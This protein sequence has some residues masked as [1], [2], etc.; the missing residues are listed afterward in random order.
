LAAG[1]PAPSFQAKFWARVE[2]DGFVPPFAIRQLR[3]VPYRDAPDA[4]TAWRQ[5]A[6]VAFLAAGVA[7]E[8]RRGSA[9]RPEYDVRRRSPGAREARKA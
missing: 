5:P 1:G 9:D 6:A 7:A 4:L 8:C 2:L 3:L